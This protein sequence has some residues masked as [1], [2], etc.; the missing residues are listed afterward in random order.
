MVWSTSQSSAFAEI[1]RSEIQSA[2][3]VANPGCFPTS[4]L[5]PLIPL[6]N[7]KLIEV[8]NIIIDSKSGGSGAGTPGRGAKEA[9]LYTEIAE[10]I[11]S[12]GV[13]RHRHA[14][15]IEQGLSD[16]ARS[17]VTISF[18]PHLMPMVKV[19]IVYMDYPVR[20]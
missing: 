4:I 15:E 16:A 13:T 7:A 11:H 19:A 3:L 1:L 5:L 18:T 9:N 10:G 12:Y 17:K 8:K 14:P 2:R 6:I 20:I